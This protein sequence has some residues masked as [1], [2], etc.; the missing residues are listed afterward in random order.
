MLEPI[1]LG[2][3]LTSGEQAFVQNLH[4]LSYA[5]GDVLYH[6]GTNLNRLAAG[7]NGQVLTTAGA[8]ANPSW[9]NAGSG[10]LVSTNNLSDVDNAATSLSN[11][12]GI[13][14]AT[15]D[16]LTNKTLDANGTG[17]TITN[18]GYAEMDT[19]IKGMTD[20]YEGMA[21]DKPDLFVVDSSGLKFEIE[22]TGGGGDM[23]FWIGNQRV[24]LD[25]TTGAGA[26]GR[27]QVALTAG[28]DANTPATNY[29][30]VTASGATGTLAA[31]TSL[32]TGAFAWIGKVIV[33]DATTWATTGEFAIQRFT[34]SME[35]SSRGLF[36]HERE[37]LRMLGALYISGGAQTLAITPNAGDVDTVHLQVA[38]AA[39]YQ[40]HRQTFPTTNTGPYYYGNGT[41]PYGQ[42]TQLA[43]ALAQD[44][45]TAITNNQRFNLVIWGAVNYSTGDCK[46]YVNLPSGVYGNDA[47]AAADTD[48]T[49]DYT[50]PDDMR[51]VA[52]M[53][54][55]VAMKYT[56]AN[57]GTWTEVGTYS[58]L[59]LPVGARSGGATAVSSNEYLDT[60]F[61]IQDDGDTTKQIAFQASGI[62][63]G[64]T[65]T[66]TMPDSDVTLK[67][68]P[69]ENVVEDTTPQL[70]GN[71]DVNG[72]DIRHA[73][74]GQYT[75]SNTDTS[76]HHQFASGQTLNSA[77]GTDKFVSIAGTINN[78][79]T[80]ATNFV[81]ID[82]TTTAAGS[83]T[84][85]L[86]SL[87]NDSAEVA[88]VDVNG[89]ITGE[90][91]HVTGDTA[92]G[93]NAALGYTAS[94]G[95]ILT[96]QGSSNDVTIKN[97]ADATVISIATG[98]TTTTFGG[99]VDMGGNDITDA[100]RII[101]DATPD[102]DH[103]ATGASTA[104]INA[105]AAIS[106]FELV[107]LHSDGEWAKADADATATTDKLLAVAL[108]AGTDGNPMDVALPGS[109]IRDDTWT[110]TVGGAIY[111]STTAGALTQTAP[112][113]T[114][115]V[116]RVVG[117]AI[118]ADVMYFMPETGV[119]HA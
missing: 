106:A 25:C 28:S 55:R 2:G 29:I 27:A 87:Q 15:T 88:A 91:I 75:P 44:D 8:A 41:T 35:N 31:S 4:G 38:T 61:R 82:A 65:R 89:N 3:E 78:S 14:A 67:A 40:L 45:G 105:G 86:L 103:T 24:T 114:D 100:Q 64:T 84:Q 47:S 7:T 60:Q 74:G 5:Q 81:E 30:Y 72:S 20:A 68:A 19:D 85:N 22:K 79:G 107:Y 56:S 90:G 52:F 63:T 66:I 118:S 95:L 92:A 71:L 26:G 70:G 109:F 37:K 96:G 73:S 49:A 101:F 18:I 102:A 94:E 46:L 58:L 111:A 80:A 117:Y 53:I 32:P 34:E 69:I 112:S 50:V 77:S 62:T 12:G 59:G 57:N 6:D 51:S 119:V 108:E 83:G 43:S 93:D 39:V 113:A 76:G 13:G 23:D 10:D 17:N 104:T 36:S 115:D 9:T 21:F 97:D 99:D 1:Y 48:N 116:V 33:P 11:I 16:T 54:A 42:I 98:T 110:W